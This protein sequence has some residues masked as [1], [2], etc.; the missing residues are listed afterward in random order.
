MPITL[1][2]TTYATT[3]YPSCSKNGLALSVAMLIVHIPFE[4]R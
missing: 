2:A 4:I 1:I 3:D